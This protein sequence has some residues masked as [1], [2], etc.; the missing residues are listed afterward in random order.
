MRAPLEHSKFGIL[1]KI[2]IIS[3]HDYDCGYHF[4]NLAKED[5]KMQLYKTNQSYHRLSSFHKKKD[6]LTIEKVKG[7]YSQKRK[8]TSTKIK[9]FE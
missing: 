7:I 3:K 1:I 9:Q 8:F 4:L 6:F 2:I 5:P